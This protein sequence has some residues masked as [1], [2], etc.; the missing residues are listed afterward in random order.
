MG[1]IRLVA[2]DIDGTVVDEHGNVVDANRAPITAA[3]GAG[4]MV[5]LVT[6]R[7]YPSAAEFAGALGLDSPIICCDGAL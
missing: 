2:L 7:A 3:T 6:A 5:V 4:V 1:R